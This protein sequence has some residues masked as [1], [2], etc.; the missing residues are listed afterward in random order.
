MIMKRLLKAI[1]LP[2]LLLVSIASFA[3]NKIVTGK[4]TDSK[5][6]AGLAGVSVTVKGTKIGVSTGS[7][8]S[9]SI[10]VPANATTLVITSSG[11]LAREIPLT[12][13]ASVLLVQG[14][15]NLNEVV[16]VAYGT[17]KK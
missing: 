9:Y 12:E 15:Q 14:T 17:R 5:T 10:T 13:A 3:Q 16:V 6:G 1:V 7:D 4:V 2:V 11:F 8:G